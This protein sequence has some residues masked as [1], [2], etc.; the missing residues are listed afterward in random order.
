VSG[1]GER[2]FVFGLCVTFY[3]TAYLVGGSIYKLLR[4]AVYEQQ[5]NQTARPH[6]LVLHAAAL[7]FTLEPYLSGETSLPLLRPAVVVALALTGW[8]AYAFIR[9]KRPKPGPGE[10]LP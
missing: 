5:V 6:I 7:V 3:G 2:D 8:S 10:T 9:R 4:R 1:P